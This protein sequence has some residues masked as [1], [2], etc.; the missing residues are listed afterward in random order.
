MFAQKSTSGSES[1][2]VQMNCCFLPTDPATARQTVT[3]EV[4][5]PLPRLYIPEGIWYSIDWA[6]AVTTSSIYIKSL[7]LVGAF[8]VGSWPFKKDWVMFGIRDD[9]R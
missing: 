1:K 6:S 3:T 2:S 5:L 4:E 9:N 7:R 8:N